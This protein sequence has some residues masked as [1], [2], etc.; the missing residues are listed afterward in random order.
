MRTP[1][2][3]A[4]PRYRYEG[5]DFTRDFD[6]D[7]W[8]PRLAGVDVVINAVGI[9]R[10]H[11]NQTFDAIHSR[12]PQALFSACAAAGVR[13]VIQISALGADEAAQSRY[14]LSKRAADDHLAGLDIASV[15]VQPSVVFGPGGA[16]TRLFTTLA[17][18][19]VIGLPGHGE[20]QLQ[21]VHIEDVV[22]AILALV[23]RL[24]AVRGTRLALAGPEPVSLR[25]FL[26]ALRRA[27]GLGDARFLPVP[28]GLMRIGA[29][30]GGVLPNSLLDPET[31]QMLERGNTADIS[32]MRT[33]L[34]RPPKPLGEFLP[35][36]DA[37][38]VRLQAQLAWLLPLLR[39][40]IAL[41][42]IWTGA[43]SLGIYPVEESYAL[44][45]RVGIGGMLAP[46]ML[47][48]AALMDLAFG[49]ATLA[50]RK[51]HRLWMAQLA[52]IL[53]YTAII[54]WKLP[55]F[56]SH[57]YGPLLKNLPMLAAIWLL[58]ELEKR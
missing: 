12:A 17:S 28:M 4:D 53:F 1:P 34:A 19:P 9:I 56:W 58:L 22:A 33:L 11:G 57:P 37:A 45:A 44:L 30:A 32:P 16:S 50:L 21:P 41:V 43:V 40:S 48:G 10:E 39:V 27:M 7:R 47:Y 29:A 38:P 46:V 42:W 31:L 18:L 25:G 26:A 36:G 52:A 6:A 8:L 35:A 3:H 49:I 15:I 23:N 2:A 55:E 24:P 51:R 14:H 20:Q 13:F 5:A 54:T